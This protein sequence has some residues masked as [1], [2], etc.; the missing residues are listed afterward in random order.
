MASPVQADPESAAEDM[1][2][3][4]RHVYEDLHDISQR[5]DNLEKILLRFSDMLDI[6]E[7]VLKRYALMTGMR[8]MGRGRKGRDNATGG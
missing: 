3:F 4:T 6:Y 8:Q 5:L 1:A 2:G 7:P